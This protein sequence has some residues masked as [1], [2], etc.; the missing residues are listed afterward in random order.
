LLLDRYGDGM[1]SAAIEKAVKGLG[2]RVGIP[3]IHPHLLRHTFGTDWLIH[4]G[5]LFSLQT[6]M[7]HSDLDVM[8]VY[9]E[10]SRVQMDVKHHQV[11]PLSR[12]GVV[13]KLRK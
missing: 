12:L 10:M 4:G 8:K 11:S 1:S 13:R 6:I 5:D 7:G 9:V 3:R 2:K